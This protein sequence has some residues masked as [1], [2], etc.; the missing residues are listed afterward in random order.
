MKSL[1][2]VIKQK[3]KF[4]GNSRLPYELYKLDEEFEPR[5]DF[6]LFRTNPSVKVSNVCILLKEMIPLYIYI[7][8][9]LKYHGQPQFSDL[10][11]RL[12][13]FRLWGRIKLISSLFIR[14]IFKLDTS[15]KK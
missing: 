4:L 13:F 1:E 11:I 2:K 8:S 10:N 5:V 9:C 7:I 6:V 15:Y 3:C 12:I 14:L